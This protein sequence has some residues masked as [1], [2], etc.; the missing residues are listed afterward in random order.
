MQKA[1][2]L[3]AV[4]LV[5]LA[6]TVAA[7]SARSRWVVT[8]AAEADENV[9]FYVALKQQNVETLFAT[10]RSVSDPSDARYGKYLSQADVRAIVAPET[11]MYDVLSGFF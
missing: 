4:A 11:E 5:L 7:G 9:T 10:A 8:R 2:V 3:L 6:S 1:A